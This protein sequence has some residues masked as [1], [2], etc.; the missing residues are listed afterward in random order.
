MDRI[1][2]LLDLIKD[3][4]LDT[5]KNIP[6]IMTY[7]AVIFYSHMHLF[8]KSK[9][10][11]EIGFRGTNTRLEGTLKSITK[12]DSNFYIEVRLPQLGERKYECPLEEN[13]I[14]DFQS[15]EISI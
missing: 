8:V 11:K 13:L 5:R 6:P 3:F 7:K 1:Y 2:T 14:K 12:S 4:K 10:G 9:A 15:T